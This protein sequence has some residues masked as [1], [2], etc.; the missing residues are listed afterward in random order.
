[1]LC[2]VGEPRKEL[3]GGGKQS[4]CWPYVDPVHSDASLICLFFVGVSRD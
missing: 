4:L 1:M 2:R 3:I